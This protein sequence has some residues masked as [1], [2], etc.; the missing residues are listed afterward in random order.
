MTVICLGSTVHI[1]ILI[2]VNVDQLHNYLILFTYT[3]LSLACMHV[4]A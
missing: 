1:V 2:F 4:I 3:E